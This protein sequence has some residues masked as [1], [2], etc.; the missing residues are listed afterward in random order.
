MSGPL[1]RARLL[2]EF[3]NP[4]TDRMVA[5]PEVGRGQVLL[6][7]VASGLNPLDTKIMAGVA[8]HAEVSTPLVLGVDVAGVV[9]AVA[10]DVRGFDVGDRVYGMTGGVG[11]HPGSLA[12][13][14]AVDA[15]L[16]AV[17][18]RRIPLR[19]S[20]S[21]PLAAISAWEGLVDR[22]SVRN[23]ETVLVHGGAGGVGSIA[24]QLAVGRGARVWAT[25]SPASFPAIEAVGAVPIDRTRAAEEYA[26]AVTGG[27]GFDVVFDTVG[28]QALDD[29]FTVVRRYTGRVVSLLGWGTHS[30][31]PLSFRGA[32]YS[33]VFT[34]LPLLTGK[35]RSHHGEIL[36]TVADLVDTGWIS[37]RLAP[38]RFD[39]SGVSTAL[40]IVASGAGIGKIVIDVSEERL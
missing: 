17:A 35:G 25:G 21:L 24:V 13:Y 27:D 19:E 7:V 4:L 11:E 3:G 32:S 38:Q 40:D 26:Q 16:I 33:G 30:L 34:L 29:S 8:A 15:R 12:E 37:P 31:A 5:V 22:A 14:A 18:P 6:R 2:E 1:M 10:Q 39:L 36:T 28:G 9:V 23:G 20:A